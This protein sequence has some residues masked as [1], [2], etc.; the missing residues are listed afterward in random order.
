[1]ND[2]NEQPVTGGVFLFYL[3]VTA[4]LCGALVMV[5]E[6]LGSRVI[7]PFF[8]VSIFVWT[9]LISVTLIA[10][11]LG[12]G[13]G[14]VIADRYSS[15]DYM[16]GFIFISGLLVL[17]IPWIAPAVIKL[18]QPLGLR[19]G[20]FTSTLLLF[21]P[22]LFLMGFV[23][24]YLIKIA[25]TE[26]SS[27]GRMVG[28]FYA[29]STFGSVIGTVLTGFLLIAYFG[30]SRIF[31]ITGSLLIIL[32]IGYFVL[33][34]KSWVFSAGLLIPLIVLADPGQ[35][36]DVSSVM[37]NGTRV[38]RV[39][40]RESFYGSVKV[41]DYEY[42]KNRT[43][44]MVI[45]GLVQGG[46]NRNTGMSI[47]PYSYFLQFIPHALHPR[48]KSC[49]VIGL[50][51]GLIPRW[52]DNRGIDTQVVDIDPMVVELAG[53]HFDYGGKDRVHIQDARY[54]LN[55]ADK[56][57]DFLILDVFNGDTTPGSLLSHEAVK[58]YSETMTPEAVL[59]INMV[60][61]LK[62]EPLMTASVIKTLKQEFDQVEIYPTF[63]PEQNG[64]TGNLVIVAYRGASREIDWGVMR[65]NAVDTFAY[66]DVWSNI[67]RRFS[68]PENTPAMV[69]TDDYNPIDFF[70]AALRESVRREIIQSTDWDM[71]L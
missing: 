19:L 67:G 51:A 33:F 26:L 6:V 9:S 22:P 21:G 15:A 41:L 40:Q 69:L 43:R 5:V 58:L 53:L 30:V 10:L 50:G 42:G 32:S 47:Y 27:L 37:S 4:V 20:A 18:S 25:A 36:A 48:G 49:L 54:F 38:T 39:D 70:D 17:L 24:P 16:Y 35:E 34:R 13:V 57:Y 52:Y 14:G 66:N 28:G 29:L 12:Y 60:G 64:G 7:G 45:D 3:V 2:K 56:V 31:D 61:S 62:R 55:T 8:G 44:E 23:S 46:I 1:M 59:G 65:R 11:A 71:L 63:D 68:F